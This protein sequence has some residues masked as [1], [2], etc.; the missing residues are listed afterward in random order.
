M[1]RLIRDFI[2]Y[3]QVERG[4]S[5][6]TLAAYGRD[7][8]KLLKY[9]Q[10][11]KIS[12]IEQCDKHFLSGYVYFL[13]KKQES[14]ASIARQ[15]ASLRGFFKFLCMEKKLETDPTIYLET[16]KLPQKLPQVL[17][18][19]EVDRLL[20]TP[21]GLFPLDL[22]DKAMLELIYATGMRVSE[23]VNLKIAQVNLELAYVRCMGKGS[24]ERI[25]PMGDLACRSVQL[26]LAKGRPFLLKNPLEK[27]L[28]L[29]H[30]GRRMTRQGFW[31]IIKRRAHEAAIKKEITP[32]TLRHSFATH[33][34]SNGADLRSV[35]ELLGHADIA[36]T[37][38]YTHLTGNKLKEIYLKAHPR[39]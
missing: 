13:K 5:H 20:E 16:P 33:M 17:S 37:Q 9:A 12:S 22:R 34:L 38:I 7:L 30:H 19:E 24:K 23:L 39:A 21:R 28:F 27:T 3:L 36:T 4:L 15:M 14:P 29:N 6:N 26:Y 1:D 8:K 35:Q 32:H 10:E 25:I 31:K 2:D 11:K 18:V